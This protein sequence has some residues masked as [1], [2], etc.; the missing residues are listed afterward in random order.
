MDTPSQ[1]PSDKPALPARR[2]AA[3]EDLSSE[4]RELGVSHIDRKVTPGD[5]HDI[6]ILENTFHAKGGPARHLHVD[7]DEWF[8]TLE[9]E[10]RFEVGEKKFHL[11]PGD[12]LLALG[13][14]RLDARLLRAGQDFNHFH[15]RR[16]DGGVF[17][18]GD[19]SRCDAAPRP[20]AVAGAR[21]GTSRPAFAGLTSARRR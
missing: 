14:S 5:A 12:S 16:Q 19:Q 3:G 9:G 1:R 6:L 13:A 15:A 7:Q 21:D 10:F 11:K 18:R 8:Y 20:G 2:L 17:P 4:Q